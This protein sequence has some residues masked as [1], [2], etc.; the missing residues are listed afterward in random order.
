MNFESYSTKKFKISIDYF[1]RIFQVLKN[2]DGS[3]KLRNVLNSEILFDKLNPET[4]LINGNAMTSI[5][6]LQNVVFNSSCICDDD[7]MPEENKIFDLT[8]D[9][10]FE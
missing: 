3:L 4:I 1:L 5:D 2:R 7:I 6:E 9:E 8:F 10:T